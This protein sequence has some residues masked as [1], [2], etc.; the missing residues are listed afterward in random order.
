MQDTDREVIYR[1]YRIEISNKP[2][3]GWDSWS[4]D[5]SGMDLSTLQEV[6]TAMNGEA[7]RLNVPWR[8][9]LVEFERVGRVVFPLKIVVD[10]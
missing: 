10:N 1:A 6:V 8:F 4:H 5:D 2:G 7:E 3:G 9:R